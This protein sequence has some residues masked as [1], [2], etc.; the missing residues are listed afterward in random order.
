MSKWGEFVF[1]K[2]C[3]YYA[4][5]KGTDADFEFALDAAL[6]R[7]ALSLELNKEITYYSIRTTREPYVAISAIGSLSKRDNL[8]EEL[9]YQASTF[10]LS[11]YHLT[12]DPLY[13]KLAEDYAKRGVLLTE[14]RYK[15]YE[16]I[17]KDFYLERKNSYQTIS[18]GKLR[19]EFIKSQ[20]K[21]N[22]SVSIQYAREKS[23]FDQTAEGDSPLAK[24]IFEIKKSR[25]WHVNL[26]FGGGS[27]V[28]E[29]FTFTALKD[30]LD[31]TFLIHH[32]LSTGDRVRPF[33]SLQN[34]YYLLQNTYQP[35]VGAVATYG[36][37]TY[38]DSKQRFESLLALSVGT[39]IGV[40]R[41]EKRFGARAFFQVG[42]FM[43]LTPALHK[44][45]LGVQHSNLF[46]VKPA[47]GVQ[48]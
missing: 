40:S 27:M 37:F 10:Y 38:E 48:F 41:K 35:Y 34:K 14:I 42:L 16:N 6:S 23:P 47:L 22:V 13:V 44:D 15:V 25:R 1:S 29:G 28:A 32:P 5:T 18:S 31:F 39:H 36:D 26:L 20:R 24:K 43:D 21:A 45:L 12:E 4:Y 8:D 33:L 30:K 3:F 7:S 11:Q 19:K 9:F 17:P 2:N 46:S